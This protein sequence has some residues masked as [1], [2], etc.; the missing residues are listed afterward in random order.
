VLCSSENIV[1]QV[2]VASDSPVARDVVSGI[3][4]GAGFTAVDLGH[5]LAARVIE[6]IPVAVFPSWRAPLLINVLIFIFL[7]AIIFAKI[8]VGY[9]IQYVIDLILQFC[10]I[11]VTIPVL[12]THMNVPTMLVCILLLCL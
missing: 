10:C 4:R 6:D 8:Q 1:L 2:Y 5:L 7:Y 3:I 12:P 11:C 9:Y